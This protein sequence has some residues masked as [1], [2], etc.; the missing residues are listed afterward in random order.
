MSQLAKGDINNN[1]ELVKFPDFTRFEPRNP[2]C[3]GR[4]NFYF[5]TES[6]GRESSRLNKVSYVSKLTHSR[7]T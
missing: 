1:Q 3:K 5:F 4:A 6:E 7:L 2:V